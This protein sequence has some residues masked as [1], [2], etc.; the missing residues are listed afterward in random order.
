MGRVSNDL[1]FYSIPP[2]MVF[3]FFMGYIYDLFGRKYTIFLS[4]LLGAC[5]M[6]ILPFASPTVYPL[7]ILFKIGLDLTMA[8]PLGHPLVTDYVKKESRG[9][10]TAV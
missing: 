1:T 8:A 2:T 4:F 7:L 10:A 6:F 5:F 9:T 3:S